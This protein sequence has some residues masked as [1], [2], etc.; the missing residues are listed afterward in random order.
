[1][2][3]M[4][5]TQTFLKSGGFVGLLLLSFLAGACG[6][7]PMPVDTI[8]NETGTYVSPNGLVAVEVKTGANTQMRYRFEFTNG[9]TLEYNNFP[10]KEWFMCWDKNNKL[11]IYVADTMVCFWYSPGQNTMIQH[12][13]A[14]IAIQDLEQMPKVFRDKLPDNIK[15]KPP[16]RRSARH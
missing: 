7:K 10:A 6:R 15:P 11:W 2:M 12:K 8:F 14:P 5:H 1:M 4:N 16:A 9:K 13:I 3:K